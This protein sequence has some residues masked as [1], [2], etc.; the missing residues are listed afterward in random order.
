VQHRAVQ[1]QELGQAGV[2]GLVVLVPVLVV[3]VLVVP[4]L[5]VLVSVVHADSLGVG[6]RS[7]TRC[8]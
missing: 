8:C 6:C 3:P 1:V 5:V 7:G 2:V 4:V